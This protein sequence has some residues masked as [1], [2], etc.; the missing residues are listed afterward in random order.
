MRPGGVSAPKSGLFMKTLLAL[1]I[2]VVALLIPASAQELKGPA[3]QQPVTMQLGEPR[4]ATGSPARPAPVIQPKALPQ[5]S[6]SL[7]EI[8]RR[9]RA[10]RAAGPKAQV[11]VNDDVPPQS[12]EAAVSRLENSQASPA[13]VTPPADL[14]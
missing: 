7:G 3:S 5:L 13:G 12:A 9:V 8:A 11:V 2:T 6:L 4:I 10:A 14:Q 1:L